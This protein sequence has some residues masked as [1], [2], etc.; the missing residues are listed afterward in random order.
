M[1]TKQKRSTNNKKIKVK[2]LHYRPEQALRI[3]GGSG[4]QN[5]RQ[6]AHEC[7]QVVSPTH[8]LSLPA[9]KYSWYSF[10]LEA[11]SNPGPQCGRK[12]Y[13]DEKFQDTIGIRW[14]QRLNKEALSGKE[15]RWNLCVKRETPTNTS[16]TAS[17]RWAARGVGC[18]PWHHGRLTDAVLHT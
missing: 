7:G 8:R 14:I 10:L 2:Q 1:L 15:R 11:E 9:R 3:A 17:P 4:S 6:S 16:L 5:S 13:V 18:I 12:D